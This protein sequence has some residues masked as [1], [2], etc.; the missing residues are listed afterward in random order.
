MK[1]TVKTAKSVGI[2]SSSRRRMCLIMISTGLVEA[3]S[4]RLQDTQS[5]MHDYRDG[6]SAADHS[7][8]AFHVP[9]HSEISN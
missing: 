9:D 2:A 7:L 5:S 4:S 1:I 3:S 8:H 6:M